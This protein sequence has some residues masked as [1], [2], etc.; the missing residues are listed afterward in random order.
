MAQ[1]TVSVTLTREDALNLLTCLALAGLSIREEPRCTIMI[2]DLA[3]RI[4]SALKAEAG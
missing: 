3:G 4:R 2:A 1:T